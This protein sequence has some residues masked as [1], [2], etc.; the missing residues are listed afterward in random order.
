MLPR[1]VGA[2]VNDTQQI[3]GPADDSDITF[4]VGAL[5][6]FADVVDGIDVLDLT[7]ASGEEGF[8]ERLRGSHVAGSGRRGEEQ[9]ARLTS[10]ALGGKPRDTRN[11]QQKA[12]SS[13]RSEGQISQKGIILISWRWW[14]AFP[15]CR[16]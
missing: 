16:E 13:L 6:K 9:D 11:C 14:S 1:L 10:H 8:F 12:S 2:F 15:G 4:V 7:I 5:K 3:R